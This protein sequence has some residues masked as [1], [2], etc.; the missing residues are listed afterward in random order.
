MLALKGR[1][2]MP[3]K[4]TTTAHRKPS[5][6]KTKRAKAAEE[7]I[8]T[9]NDDMQECIDNCTDCFQ[10]CEQMITHCLSKGGEHA[11]ANHIRLL[12]DCAEACKTSVGFMLRNSPYHHLTCGVCAQIC[13]A[14]AD[15]CETMNDDE[16]MKECIEIC[17]RCAT[18]C[19]AMAQMQ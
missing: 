14:C 6:P 17:R 13:T 11:S 7:T 8:Y 19:A 16:M 10:V 12:V 15:D 3:T 2:S 1:I 4:H 18:S 5:K 9:R